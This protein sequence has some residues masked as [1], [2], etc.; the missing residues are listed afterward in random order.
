[1]DLY[2]EQVTDSVRHERTG[3]AFG[4]Q[5]VGIA[6]GGNGGKPWRIAIARPQPGEPQ[7]QTLLEIGTAA[8]ATSGGYHNS[9]ELLEQPVVLLLVGQQV[10][11][12]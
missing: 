12:Q 4:N 10:V 7:A 8:I 3:H 5:R 2:A 1:M 9:I 6:G 11:E